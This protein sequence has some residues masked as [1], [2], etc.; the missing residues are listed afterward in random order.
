MIDVK[1]LPWKHEPAVCCKCGGCEI[2]SF[3]ASIPN[4][5]N[6]DG[7]TLM[8][9]RADGT[10]QCIPTSIGTVYCPGGQ[11]PEKE[12]TNPIAAMLHVASKTGAV[13]P[14]FDAGISKKSINICAGIGEEHLHRIC[15]R[16]QYEWLTQTKDAA[17]G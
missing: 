10:E 15:G 8:A 17:G 1:I 13:P 16:C 5:F 2:I 4:P 14:G 7:P 9:A 12:E 6:T 3:L 11:E